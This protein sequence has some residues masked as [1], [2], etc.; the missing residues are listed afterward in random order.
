MPTYALD[1]EVCFNLVILIG[2]SKLMLK[3]SKL[4][5]MLESVVAILRDAS[6]NGCHL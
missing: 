2:S 1:E 5:A 4:P 6:N 3:P